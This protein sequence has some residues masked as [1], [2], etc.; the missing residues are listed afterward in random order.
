MFKKTRLKK[1][2]LKILPIV[3]FIIYS[4]FGYF[5]YFFKKNFYHKDQKVQ[6]ITTVYS[7]NSSKIFQKSYLVLAVIDG[8]TIEVKIDSQR[9]RIRLIGVN[10]PEINDQRKIVGCMGRLAK[11]KL[12]K[13]LIG[14]KVF[15][16]GDPSQGNR[17]RYNRL[18]RYV[19]LEDGIN[20]NYWLIKEGYAYEYTYRFPYLYQMDFQEAQRKAQKEKKGLWSENIDC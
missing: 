12:K 7:A 17:D 14:K 6:D 2:Y 18:L 20:I 15:L 8:D 19:F 1:F 3:F 4:F 11:E 9:E 13:I 16:K 5:N 10:S